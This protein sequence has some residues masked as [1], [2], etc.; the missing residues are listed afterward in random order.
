MADQAL[1]YIDQTLFREMPRACA[2]VP[3]P[4]DIGT[5]RNL[6]DGVVRCASRWRQC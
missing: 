1:Y 6:T 3:R 4:Y 2:S 5:E